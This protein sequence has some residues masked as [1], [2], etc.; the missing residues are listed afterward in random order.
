MQK[1]AIVTGGARGIGKA[2]TET[3]AQNGIK[4]IANYNKSKEQA[5]K[6]KKELE[7]KNIIID[8]IQ[9][10]ISKKEE[11]E[12]IIEYTIKKYGKIDILINN[13]G[14]LKKIGMK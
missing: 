12:K 8:I 5:E 9:A 4:V 6:L 14:I 2:I 11:C 1:I 7:E 10:D 3:L 13:A